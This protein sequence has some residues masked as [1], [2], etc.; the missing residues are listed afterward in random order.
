M[1]DRSLQISR[2]IDHAAQWHGDVEIVTL[3]TGM[4]DVRG[5]YRELRARSAQL[6]HA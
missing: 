6:A 4:P 3:S 1:M 5:T 2:L